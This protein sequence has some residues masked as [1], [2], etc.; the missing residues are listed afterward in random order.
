MLQIN[1]KAAPP[2]APLLKKSAAFQKNNIV[3]PY[4]SEVLY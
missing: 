2:P 4:P 3:S 1:F